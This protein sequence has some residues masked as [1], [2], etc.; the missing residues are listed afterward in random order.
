MTT[1]RLIVEIR[2]GKMA[3]KKV[4]VDPGKSLRVGRTELAELVVSHDGQMSGVH[5]E[6]SWSGTHC[7]LRDLSS[8]GGTKLGGEAVKDAE[9]RHGG[10]IQ[11]GDTDFMVY[12]EG[13][14]KPQLRTLDSSEQL[15]EDQRLDGAARVL[16][17]LRNEKAPVYALV[18]AGRDLRVLELLR[19]HVEPHHSLYDGL[20]GETLEDVAPY[21]VGPMRR[22]SALLENLVTE[23][24][25]KRW[26]VFVTTYEKFVEVRR[27]FR[28]F[29]K[30]QMEYSH[31]D[32][33]FRFFD[34]GVLRPFW[35]TCNAGQKREFAEGME[36]IY[37]E[38]KNFSLSALLQSTRAEARV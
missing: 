35:P 32:V 22:D 11:A 4:I 25:G 16:L 27:H 14:L 33:F 1:P 6:L 13:R 15:I 2:Y 5:F 21:L 29:L 18:D 12:M 31:E 34:P 19:Q 17:R 38:E 7:Q 23:G 26:A 24:F 3:G 20:D 30:V 28:R 10:W 37:V 9:V 8:I 36:Q